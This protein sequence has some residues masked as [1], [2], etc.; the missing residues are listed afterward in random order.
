MAVIEDLKLDHPILVGHSLGGQELSS[1]G[2]RQPEKIA[3]LIYLDAAYQ[4]AYYDRSKGFLDIE[5]NEVR[6]RLEQLELGKRPPNPKPLI[7]ELL[8]T[9]LPELERTLRQIQERFKDA[10][11]QPLAPTKERPPIPPI[12]AAMNR[13]SQRYT[14]IRAP[15]LAIYALEAVSGLDGSPGRAD[16]EKRN[17]MKRDQAAAF[18]AGV[19]GARVVRLENA[20]H[21]VFRSNE[22]EVLRE[23]NDFIRSLPKP[24]DSPKT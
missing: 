14:D 12:I 3:G 6:R 24:G 20:S 13:G 7:N 23:M 22:S 2:S 4:Y 5:V 1:I 21:D 18:Q 16:V 15:V 9:S 11:T 8:Q 10:P 17:Q 19:P